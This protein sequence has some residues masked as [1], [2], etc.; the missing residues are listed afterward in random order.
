MMSYPVGRTLIRIALLAAL[1]PT[2]VA[3]CAAD[4]GRGDETTS[5]D[6]SSIELT[7][8]SLGGDVDAARARL[9]GTDVATFTSS[10][11]NPE[12]VPISPDVLH[13]TA[14]EACSEL[15]FNGDAPSAFSLV[16]TT[17]QV[18]DDAAR[19]LVTA[20]VHVLC[21]AELFHLPR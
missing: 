20:G 5:I 3:G 1:A 18:S 11:T 21:P 2:A 8:P 14:L 7:Q 6:A 9:L 13:Q 12:L 10:L 16:S 15:G 19:E 4:P 17:L